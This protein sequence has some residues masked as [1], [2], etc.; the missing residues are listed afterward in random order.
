MAGWRLVED[1]FRGLDNVLLRDTVKSPYKAK[2][3]KSRTA[4][5]DSKQS[6]GSTPP[7]AENVLEGSD[8]ADNP[9]AEN[10]DSGGEVG[11]GSCVGAGSDSVRIDPIT[12]QPNVPLTGEILNAMNIC[13]G[14]I[15]VKMVS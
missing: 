2:S 13:L 10:V 11:T 5:A 7:E 14:L 8:N 3:S 6:T 12:H 1:F 15:E 9:A 4:R